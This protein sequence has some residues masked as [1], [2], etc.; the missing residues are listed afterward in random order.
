VVFRPLLKTSGCGS[1]DFLLDWT[2]GGTSMTDKE[3]IKLAIATLDEVRNEAFRLVRN[4]QRFYAEEKVWNTVA[5]LKERLA[6]PHETT[7]KEFNQLI[8]DDPKYHIWAKEKEALAEK[9]MREVQRLGQEIE[10]EPPQR[11]WVGLTYD[12]FKQIMLA[13]YN[14]DLNVPGHSSDDYLLW[15]AIEAKLKEK[16]T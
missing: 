6:Q 16:N 10:Q 2:W 9:S 4:G 5:A 7:L 1:S 12:E 15:N 13:T 8:Y 14:I 3:A 11:T